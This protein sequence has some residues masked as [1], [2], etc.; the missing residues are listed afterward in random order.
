MPSAVLYFL[1]GGVMLAGLCCFLRAF[2]TRFDTPVHKRWGITGT[3]ISLFGILVVV[4]G[5]WLWG[6]RVD[7]RW[8]AVVRVHRAV[9]LL[10]LALLVLT[11][12]TGMMRHRIHPKLYK[13]FLPV[14]V[15]ALITAAFG[16]KP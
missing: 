7:E 14:Y 16:Y 6:W 15:I 12:T 1:Y 5:A 2:Q 4:A 9:A 8:P 13:V 3:A 11:A 10:A